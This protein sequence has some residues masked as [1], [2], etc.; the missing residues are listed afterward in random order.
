MPTQQRQRVSPW[1]EHERFVRQCRNR[2]YEL[3]HPRRFPSS[4]KGLRKNQL[5]ARTCQEHHVLLT[6]L[7]SAVARVFCSVSM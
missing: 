1:D 5:P 2:K 7:N 4:L 6:C 3:P